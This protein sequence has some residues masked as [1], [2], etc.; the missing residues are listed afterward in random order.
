MAARR[1]SAFDEKRA[2]VAALASADPREALPELRRLLGDRVAY[3]AGGAAEAAAKLE[4]RDL[5]PDMTTAFQR[6]LVDPLTSDKGCFGKTRILE[7]LL[8]LEA[9]TPEVYL[10]AVH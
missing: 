5:V 1:P 9:Y 2:R 4:L 10:A 8:A 6:L 3:I 7:A